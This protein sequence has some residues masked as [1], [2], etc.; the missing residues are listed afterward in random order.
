[1]PLLERIRFTLKFLRIA[2]P[3]VFTVIQQRILALH[4]KWT[5][6]SVPAPKDIVVLGGSFTGIQLVRRLQE[7]V[8]SGYRVTLIERNSHFH[9]LFNFPRYSVMTGGREKYAF[10]PFDGIAA[11]A[12]RGAFR[13]IQDTATSIKDGRVYLESGRVVEYA[14]LVIATGSRGSVPAKLTST[15]INEACKEMQ[16]V[17]E[18]IQA[19]QRIAVVGGGAVGVEL[20]ADIKSFYPEKDV[21]IVHS[22]ER[23][24]SRFRPRL[25]D[26]V[27]EKLQDMGINI[28]LNERPQIKKG[29]N[30]LL[31]SNGEIRDYDLILPC[32]GQTPNSDIIKDLAPEAICPKTNHVLVKPTLQIDTSRSSNVFAMGDVAETGGSR[33]ASAGFF[34]TETILQNIYTMIRGKTPSSVYKPCLVIEGRLKLS[35]GKDEGVLYIED[36]DGTDML[37]PTKL[38]LLDLGIEEAW[39][40]LYLKFPGK[41]I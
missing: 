22:R 9:Y 3:I 40:V 15:E 33:M 6:H 39:T 26:Y 32:A 19:A 35:L 8:P 29:K 27:Y 4:H 2:I 11:T 18:D 36:D 17:Q 28:I 41:L 13:H 7:S 21:T 24:L 25:H 16:S 1:M 34:Q 37:S 5:Y 14:Y 31:F 12:P 23:L 10:I 30:A 20:A 38:K